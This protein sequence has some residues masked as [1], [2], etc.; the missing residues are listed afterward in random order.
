MIMYWY[1]RGLVGLCLL[2]GALAICGAVKLMFNPPRTWAQASG[3]DA[4]T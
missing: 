2:G 1:I 3:D 4:W